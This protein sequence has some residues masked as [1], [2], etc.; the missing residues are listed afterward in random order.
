MLVATG[1]NSPDQ[2]GIHNLKRKFEDNEAEIISEIYST[3]FRARSGLAE[4]HQG[5]N[6]DPNNPAR[7]D[8]EDIDVEEREARMLAPGD[9]S[10]PPFLPMD[11]VNREEFDSIEATENHS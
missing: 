2:D 5:D 9:F 8:D 1:A 4:G 11:K 7:G 10:P 6:D 3:H